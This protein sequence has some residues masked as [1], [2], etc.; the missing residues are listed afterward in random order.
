MEW[1]VIISVVIILILLIG[2]IFLI[3][4]QSKEQVQLIETYNDYL[5]EKFFRTIDD[6]YSD[7]PRASVC[8]DRFKT[9]QELGIVNANMLYSTA[10]KEIPKSKFKKILK[11]LSETYGILE[12]NNNIMD[13]IN[14][15][16]N[17]TT[18][19]SGNESVECLPELRLNKS[20]TTY[21]FCKIWL[22]RKLNEK[23]IEYDQTT[24]YDHIPLEIQN[25]VVLMFKQ[26]QDETKNIDY[27]KFLLVLNR[28]NK[29]KVFTIECEML[30]DK[31]YSESTIVSL[32]L[33]GLTT[34]ENSSSGFLNFSRNASYDCDDNGVSCSLSNRPECKAPEAADVANERSQQA[35]EE[36]QMRDSKCFYKNADNKV[37]CISIDSSGCSGIWDTR[38]KENTDCPFY[39][40]KGNT[41]YTNDR[42]GCKKDG[43]CELPLNMI[44]MAYRKYSTREEDRPLC[45]NCPEIV[46]CIGKEC[47]QCCHL[48]GDKPDYAFEF[49]KPFRLKAKD[50]LESAG[51]KY[52]DI[53]F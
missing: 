2:S 35:E 8:F 19:A 22:L 3:N 37:D 41:N 14:C 5:N 18:S 16:Q 7:D 4:K 28:E 17:G 25:D 46:G 33:K 42:G 40:A 39:G 15:E 32:E 24:E 51:L 6:T 53:N 50:E 52:F 30:Y 1:N 47:S 21:F 45:H 48:Q 20:T 44:N 11:Q 13:I 38:C 43:H 27:F 34:N 26:V 9:A 31:N 23:M 29:N 12:R 49:D 10:K 36:A